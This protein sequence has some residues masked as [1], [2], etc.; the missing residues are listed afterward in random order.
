M[1]AVTAYTPT[2]WVNDTPPPLSAANMNKLTNE[3][4]SQATAKSIAN[5]LP[6]WQ[7]GSGTAL[8]DAAALNEMERVCQLVAQAVGL[9]YTKT[10]WS[11]GWSP[12]R[13]AA[14]FNK[15]GRAHV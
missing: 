4:K 9:S 6:T 12:P 7:D 10:T 5:T 2:S 14:N 13:N 11:A 15:I 3:L 8:S 1:A